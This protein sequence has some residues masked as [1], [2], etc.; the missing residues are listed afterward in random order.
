MS[1][2]GGEQVT[3]TTLSLEIKTYLLNKKSGE[4][5]EVKIKNHEKTT[6]LS[7]VI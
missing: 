2:P 1:E 4:S 7:T 3:T 6:L 5:N